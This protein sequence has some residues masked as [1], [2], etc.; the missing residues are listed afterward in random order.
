MVYWLCVWIA[1]ILFDCVT[2]ERS[3]DIFHCVEMLRA[4]GPAEIVRCNQKDE[5]Y[6]MFIKRSLGD[7]AQSVFG[8]YSLVDYD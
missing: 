3:V 6:L 5:S 1:L 7:I 4:A 2:F 8:K